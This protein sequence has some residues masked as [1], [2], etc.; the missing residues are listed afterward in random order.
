MVYVKPDADNPWGEVNLVMEVAAG[1]GL[2]ERLVSE[3]AY[4]EQLASRI[5]AKLAGAEVRAPDARNSEQLGA[6]FSAQFSDAIRA[7]LYRRQ[8][9]HAAQHL[10]LGDERR[11]D[12]LGDHDAVR[13]DEEPH[14]VPE[15][16]LTP[17]PTPLMRHGPLSCL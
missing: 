10:L 9:G 1:G 16:R 13:D 7:S 2:F 3:G 14:G 8:G 11:A 12:L 6:Q 17:N 5:D 15:A 4:S